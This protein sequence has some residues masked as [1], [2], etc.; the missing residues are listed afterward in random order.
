MLA[1]KTWVS[2]G[3]TCLYTVLIPA[4]SKRARMFSAMG[5]ANGSSS[6]VYAAVL[7]RALAGS[8]RI[9]SA[10]TSPD[11][12]V[13]AG[14]TKN[15]LCRFCA[16]TAGPP[17]AGSRNE[18]PYRLATCDAGTVSRLEKGPTTRLTLSRLIRFW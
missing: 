15:R 10:N 13:G 16:K 3:Q 8:E 4:A 14:W 7:G 5:A 18:Y 6:S 11:F 12:V 1:E 9:Q 2:A 17:P